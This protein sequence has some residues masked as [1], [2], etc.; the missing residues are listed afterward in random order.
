[1]EKFGGF[2]YSIDLPSLTDHFMD[3]CRY[4][5]N[6]NPKTL[7]AYKID[8]SQFLL[9]MK[10][11]DG[12]LSRGNL[13]EYSA[14]LHKTYK[15]K[16]IKRKIAC[17]RAFCRWMEYEEI[18]RE[19]PFDKLNLKFQEPRLLPRTIPLDVIER[20][21]RTAYCNLAMPGVTACKYNA[22][23]RSI[24]V[25]ELLFATGIR[26][27]ELCTLKPEDINLSNR[28]IRIFGKGSKERIIQI[29]N[30]EVISALEN[31]RNVFNEKIDHAGYFF[32]NRLC[33]R[34]SEQSV[35]FMI[36][37]YV[38]QTNIHVHITPHMFRHS[39][40]TLLLEEDVDIRYIQQIL[41]HSS[42]LTTQVYTHVSTRKQK[43]ILTQKHPRNQIVMGGYIAPVTNK[44][45]ALK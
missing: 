34:L 7:K 35:R 19:S 16:T 18:I 15:P 23:L 1:V 39:F 11:T 10:N 30:S 37:R 14:A 5:K 33:Q 42:I 2:M 13:S 3:F 12:E 26:V 22:A 32:V 4:Q 38:E 43:D 24:A 31:Y 36:R 40:A 27:S 29:G 8:L 21:L 20:I 45:L 6:L 25:L 9:F 41:G 17:V 44:A 28:Y